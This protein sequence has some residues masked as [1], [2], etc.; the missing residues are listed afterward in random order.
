MKEFIHVLPDP[1]GRIWLDFVGKCYYTP[2]SFLK[3]AQNHGFSRYVDRCGEIGDLVIFAQKNKVF[4]LGVV[5]GYCLP[6][7][8]LKEITQE[9]SNLIKVT[10]YDIPAPEFRGCGTLFIGGEYHVQKGKE[11]E[12]RELINQKIRE[13]RRRGEKLPKI[14]MRGRIIKVFTPPIKL[15]GDYSRMPYTVKITHSPVELQN[16]IRT[17]EHVQNLIHNSSLYRK[18]D[19][20]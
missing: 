1:Q 3:E 17:V 14:F 10:Y 4:A 18:R 15:I 2:K 12:F 6:D 16:I 7:D 11:N 13:K 20:K 9:Q 8:L 19:P 5:E